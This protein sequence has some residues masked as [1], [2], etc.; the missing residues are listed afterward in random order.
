MPAPTPAPPPAVPQTAAAPTPA[1][2]YKLSEHAPGPSRSN[3]DLTAALSRRAG[4]SPQA[5]AYAEPKTIPSQPPK[6]PEP[7]TPPVAPDDDKPAPHVKFISAD[8]QE[9]APAKAPS[10]VP[11][12]PP[13]EVVKNAPAQ[14]REAYERL[15][16]DFTTRATEG[17]LTKKQ[18]AEFQAKSKSY[19]DRIK[20]LE[21]AEGRAKEL[22]K[23]LLTYD[24][25]LRI[26]NYLQHPE[27]HEKFVKP[28]AEAVQSGNAMVKEIMVQGE[29]RLGNEEDFAAVLSQPNNTLAMDK[30]VEL[31][32]ERM[33]VSVFDE[34]RRVKRLQQEQARA[35]KE[36]G[37]RSM[38]W[39]K[40]QQES[41]AK[42]RSEARQTF[43][44]VA[45]SLAEKYPQLY[46]APEGDKDAAAARKSGEELAR[47]A[48]DGQ[49]EGMTTEQ[50]LQ[51]IAKV[52]HRAASFPMRELAIS[53]LQSE[54]EATKAK[55]AA[56]EKSSPD[57]DSRKSAAGVT[58]DAG[59]AIVTSAN[60]MKAQMRASL[61]RRAGLRR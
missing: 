22:E 8:D 54:L 61:E 53:R 51:A 32:G 26:S 58:T 20:S 50:Y 56:Y 7:P 59:G 1:A 30:A 39:L 60:D 14:L 55:L 48:L 3:P 27:F 57:A 38:E 28:V 10:T 24:E 25:Q 4:V 47:L 37:V 21:S 43:D 6:P 16:A 49:P 40:T 35:V 19:E 2:E 44:R 45:D 5:P 36:S 29:N 33:G 23:Q 11:G 34:A 52:Y 18:L 17:D 9:P 12:E 41:Q 15:K 42:A 46:R 13:A 31:F